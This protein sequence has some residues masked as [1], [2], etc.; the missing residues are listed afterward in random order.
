MSD[1]FDETAAFDEGHDDHGGH[2]HAAHGPEPLPGIDPTD[3]HAAVD[4]WLPY[5]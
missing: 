4:R 5:R 2:D 3:L 1:E